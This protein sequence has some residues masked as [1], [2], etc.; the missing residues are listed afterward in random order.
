METP[1]TP[2]VN[3][4]IIDLTYLYEIADG[5]EEFIKKMMETFIEQ[6]PPMLDKM[7][8]YLNEKKW[9]ELSD[10]AHKMKPTIDFIGIHSIRDAIK[11]IENYSRTQINL[12]QLPILVKLVND[13]CLKAIDELKMEI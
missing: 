5:S 6:T 1:K 12:D 10:I 4:K 7:D 11:N 3:A 2:N 8:L 13:T 9:N